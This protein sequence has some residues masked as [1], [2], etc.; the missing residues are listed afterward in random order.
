MRAFVCVIIMAL[1]TYIPRVMPITI[2]RKEIKSRFLKSFLY[3]VPYA[4]LA[5]L[6]FP[7]IFWATGNTVTAV[8]GTVAA[9]ILAICNRGLVVVAV[10]A[11]VCTY[12][13]GQLF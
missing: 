4:V 1:V 9:I 8:F 10:G 5:A 2:F 11:I 3:Y 12:L 7:G 13:A 6:T